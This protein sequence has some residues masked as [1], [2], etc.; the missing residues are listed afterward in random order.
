MDWTTN[1]I[2]CFWNHLSREAQR[3]IAVREI[4]CKELPSGT[5]FEESAYFVML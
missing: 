1:F 3:Y 2:G 5:S 4:F